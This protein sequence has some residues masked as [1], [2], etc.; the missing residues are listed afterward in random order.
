MSAAKRRK[1]AAGPAI[2][3]Y[4][5]RDRAPEI[6]P[7]VIVVPLVGFDRHGTRIGYGKGH[8]DRTIAGLRAGGTAPVLIGVA[9]SAQEVETIPHEP[10]DVRIDVIA[11]EN[12]ILDFRPQGAALR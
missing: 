2:T 11:T 8:Y 9:F 12:E 5:I 3:C 10:H 6:V 1:A 7:D 4:R